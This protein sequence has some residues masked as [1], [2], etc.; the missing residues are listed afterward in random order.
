[1]TLTKTI[2][3]SAENLAQAVNDAMQGIESE[4]TPDAFLLLVKDDKGH[5]A[6]VVSAEDA[7]AVYLLIKAV[8]TIA[9]GKNTTPAQVLEFMKEAINTMHSAEKP[10]FH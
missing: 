9:E 6:V 2:E 10:I 7:D 8:E 1:M 5:S 4:M 3:G